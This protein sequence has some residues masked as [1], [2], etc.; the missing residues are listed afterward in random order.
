MK[1]ILLVAL[2]ACLC[3][4]IVIPAAVADGCGSYT[5]TYTVF[6]PQYTETTTT[7]YGCYQQTTVEYQCPPCPPP[8]PPDPCQPIPPCVEKKAVNDACKM[9]NKFTLDVLKQLDRELEGTGWVRLKSTRKL[10]K[11]GR[12]IY[13]VTVKNQETG[14]KISCFLV[15][16]TAE[17]VVQKLM[18]TGTY[19]RNG[20][21]CDP[22]S[23][24]HKK[25]AKC[26]EYSVMFVWNYNTGCNAA[27]YEDEWLITEYGASDGEAVCEFVT[28]LVAE[29]IYRW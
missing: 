10:L 22:C 23:R 15:A 16:R 13:T 19:V 1:R 17:N 25:H 12:C 11:S 6:M 2:V 5:E 20:R 3:M 24:C 7:T 9:I 21:S 26:S 27:V 4:A 18:E 14:E 29:E 8:C 28:K